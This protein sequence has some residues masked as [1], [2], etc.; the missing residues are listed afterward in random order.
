MSA[1][2]FKF[3]I[4]NEYNQVYY[5]KQNQGCWDLILSSFSI[6]SFFQSLT[7]RLCI[8]KFSSKISPELLDL[9]FWNL[10]QTSDMRSCIIQPHIAYQSL[11]PFFFPIK[12]ASDGYR[13]G[14][15]SFAHFLLYFYLHWCCFV[16]SC[17]QFWNCTLPMITAKSIWKSILNTRDAQKSENCSF[18][19]ITCIWA[20]WRSG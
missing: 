9:E 15:V 5:C 11:Y 19:G 12:M 3:C 1:T 18:L 17:A 8:W 2:V 10:V 6:F 14:Y 20:D 7:P 4:H 16:W 13:R